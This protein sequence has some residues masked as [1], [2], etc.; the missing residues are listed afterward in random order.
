MMWAVMPTLLV[1]TGFATL[2]AVLVAPYVLM[3]QSVPRTISDSILSDVKVLYV[4]SLLATDVPSTLLILVGLAL[5]RRETI[6]LKRNWE[7]FRMAG[8]SPR[9]ILLGLAAARIRGGLL[10]LLFSILLLGYVAWLNFSESLDWILTL[11]VYLDYCLLVPMAAVLDVT[12]W[13][14][15]VLARI[16]AIFLLVAT[17]PLFFL[18]LFEIAGDAYRLPADEYFIPSLGWLWFIARLL[19]ISFL[20]HRTLRRLETTGPWF[21]SL[22]GT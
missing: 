8:L 2:F 12:L 6:I 17:M 5:R 13:T 19:L 21:S 10:Y 4:L 20:W 18:P 22:P 11:V 1:L 7:E 9:Q 16:A 3:P 14:R 15:P